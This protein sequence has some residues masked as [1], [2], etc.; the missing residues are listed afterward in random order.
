MLNKDNFGKNLIMLSMLKD[1]FG[2]RIM[3]ACLFCTVLSYTIVY[4][5]YCFRMGFIAFLTCSINLLTYLLAHLKLSWIISSV[6]SNYVKLLS[7]TK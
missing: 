1:N 5:L 3:Y 7:I 4:A 6:F 2:K